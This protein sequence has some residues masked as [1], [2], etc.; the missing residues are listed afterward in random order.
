MIPYPYPLSPDH[1][2]YNSQVI[3]EQYSRENSSDDSRILIL[4]YLTQQ[5]E[6][7]AKRDCSLAH[8][9]RNQHLRCV[10]IV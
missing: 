3:C 8:V 1:K 5:L 4:R 6:T 9:H 2:D 7:H 10:R